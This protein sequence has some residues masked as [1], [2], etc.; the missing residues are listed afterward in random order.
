MGFFPGAGWDNL[1]LEPRDKMSR[2]DWVRLGVI[3]TINTV[4]IIGLFVCAGE[5]W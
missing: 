5:V 3:I 1:R 4:V 2:G